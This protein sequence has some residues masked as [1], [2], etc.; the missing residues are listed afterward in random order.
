MILSL[1]PTQSFVAWFYFVLFFQLSHKTNFILVVKILFCVL[2]DY[3][4]LNLTFL[5]AGSFRV[6]LFIDLGC[7]WDLGTEW[8]GAFG[9][10]MINR[11][12]YQESD[13]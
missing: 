8:R 3:T 11:P 6:S 9:T 13:R 1:N 12:I 2:M 5:I 7:P 10:F 4:K